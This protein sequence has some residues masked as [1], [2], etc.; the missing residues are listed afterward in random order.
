MKYEDGKITQM[1]PHTAIDNEG[2]CKK[3]YEAMAVRTET[4]RTI[5]SAPNLAAGSGMYIP[6]ER[7]AREITIGYDVTYECED[8]DSSH[9]HRGEFVY[10]KDEC[11]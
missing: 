5:K 7:N 9:S 1:C 11:V 10:L 4:S 2:Q 6:D 3:C 8:C